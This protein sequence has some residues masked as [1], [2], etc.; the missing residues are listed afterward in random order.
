MAYRNLETSNREAVRTITVNRPD[1]LNALDRDTLNELTLAFAQAAQDD[2]VRVVV[3]AGAGEK[4][5]VAGADIAEMNGY[6]PVQAQGFSR[7]GQRL[8]SSIE[9]LGKPVIARIQ[10]FALGGGMELAMACHLRVASEK[11][12]FGQPEINLGLIPG[13][14]GTQRLLR[15]AGRGAAL[16]LC[17]TGAVINAQ[18]AYELGVVTRVVAA[19]VLDETVNALADQLA[20]AAPLAAAGI[21]DAVL[22][23]GETGIDQGLEFETQGFALAFSTEDMREGTSAFLEKRKAAFKGN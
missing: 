1:K 11:A 14:G 23:G 20:A 5:F 15:L 3:L 7:T 18:R 16:E 21:L 10:G 13:F 8:M 6:T 2:S 19:D 4:A 12:K 22:Q 9:R 17:L